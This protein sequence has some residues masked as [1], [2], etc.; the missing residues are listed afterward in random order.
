V[1][2]YRSDMSKD[3]RIRGYFSQRRGVRQN[4]SLRNIGHIFVQSSLGSFKAWS[5]L[6]TLKFS[7]R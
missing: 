6:R 4:K 3:A 5:T 1:D 7:S 2:A